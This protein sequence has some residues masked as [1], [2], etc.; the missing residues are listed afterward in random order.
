MAKK[1]AVVTGAA[2]AIGS[3]LCRAF[4]QEGF[5]VVGTDRRQPADPAQCDRFI[6]I[7]LDSFVQDQ[8][9]RS[10][11]TRSIVEAIGE[12][13]HALINNAA[14]QVVAPVGELTA[15]NWQESLNVNLL[16][17]FFLIQGLL[18]YLRDSG[19]AVVNIGSIHSTLTK[20]RFSCYATS[21][22]ALSGLTRSL[23]VEL[24]GAVRINEL[25]PAATETPML[26][27]GFA[28]RKEMLDKLGEAHPLG[29]IASPDE[30]AQ[31]AVFLT[32]E[33]ASFIT[34]TSLRIDGGIGSRLHD[35][36]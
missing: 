11:A 23:A 32:S 27:S 30:V 3:A 1:T 15:E 9:Y 13:L 21:K 25:V 12:R 20:P 22:A 7:D 6:D 36:E 26:L 18:P 35:P 17:P 14:T 24:G 16:A 34:G 4:K 33:R 5:L 29:R 31:A 10:Q 8:N 2:G 19:G 28:G